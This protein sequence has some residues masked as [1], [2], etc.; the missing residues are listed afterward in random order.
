MINKRFGFSLIELIVVISIL[1]IL[2]TLWFSSYT[3]YLSDTRDTQ[4]KSDITLINNSI[5]ELQTNTFNLSRLVNTGSINRT[6]SGSA[7][8]FQGKNIA[9]VPWYSAWEI[10]FKYLQQ[11][12]TPLFDPKTLKSYILWV[13]NTYYE[14]AGTLENTNSSYILSSF[15]K[16]T[17]ENTQALIESK[18]EPNSFITLL[19]QEDIWF[20]QINDLIVIGS[21]EYIITDILGKRIYLDNNSNF[22]SI[23]NWSTISL[24]SSDTSL[25]WNI[26]NGEGN[27]TNCNILT[28]IMEN[29]CP[30]SEN[31]PQLIPY[32]IK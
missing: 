27:S 30:L 26:Q 10:N 16:R 24:K 9:G 21:S 31:I 3:K 32:I 5:K 28:N 2:W 7:F 6:W 19:N 18:D 25:I 22:S 15:K 8:S 29:I 20:Y 12:N 23:V 14:I 11:I 1:S 17:Q 4:R 13:Y